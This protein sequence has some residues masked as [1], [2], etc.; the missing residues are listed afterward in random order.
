[1]SFRWFVSDGIKS[2]VID[3]NME[4]TIFEIIW[5]AVSPSPAPEN[6]LCTSMSEILSRSGRM[7][8]IIRAYKL[9]APLLSSLFLASLRLAWLPFSFPFPPSHLP[10]L[11]YASSLLFFTSPLGVG[12]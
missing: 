7:Q 5:I 11:L 9:I 6:V 4:T 2:M 3:H 12:G 8:V 1:M 10:S